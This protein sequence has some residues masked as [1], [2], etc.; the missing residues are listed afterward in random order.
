LLASFCVLAQDPQ[1][2]IVITHITTAAAYDSTTVIQSSGG[3]AHVGCHCR[4]QLSAISYRLSAISFQSFLPKAENR[5]PK[6][7]TSSHQHT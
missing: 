7:V 2:S 1:Q 5:K 3:R 6:P 4:Y